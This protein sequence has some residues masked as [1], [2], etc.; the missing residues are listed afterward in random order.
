MKHYGIL[1]ASVGLLA[2]VALSACVTSG[3]QEPASSATPSGTPYE[4]SST[5]RNSVGQVV[6]SQAQVIGG[7]DCSVVPRSAEEI[8][9]FKKNCV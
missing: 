9:L 5:K 3:S 1:T 2:V 4:G 7:V 8:E 6:P